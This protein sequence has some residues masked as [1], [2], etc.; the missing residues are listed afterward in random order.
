MRLYH[1]PRCSKSRMALSLLE[2]HN[3]DFDI[4]LYQETPLDAPEL[5]ALVGKLDVPLRDIVRKGEDAFRDLGLG[6]PGVSDDDL[7][8]AIVAHPGLLERPIFVHG[9]RAAVGRPPEAV[10]DIL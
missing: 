6:E 7:I 10:L 8:A 4:V 3:V 5:R 1:N 9:Q 2:S